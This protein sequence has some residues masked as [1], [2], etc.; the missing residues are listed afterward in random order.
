MRRY[1]ILSIF[2]QTFL[3]KSSNKGCDARCTWHAEDGQKRTAD[4]FLLIKLR[5]RDTAKIPL[6]V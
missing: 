2:Q 6:G 4:K 3:G 5:E 1:I